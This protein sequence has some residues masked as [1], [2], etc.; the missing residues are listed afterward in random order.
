MGEVLRQRR[1]ARYVRPAIDE[2]QTSVGIAHVPFG[3]LRRIGERR[4]LQ[5]RISRPQSWRLRKILGPAALRAP[6]AIVD[7]ARDRNVERRAIDTRLSAG[8]KLH[9][10]RSVAKVCLER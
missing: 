9:C 7:A 4:F 5:L 1:A 3:A 8:E 10:A 6:A 2:D